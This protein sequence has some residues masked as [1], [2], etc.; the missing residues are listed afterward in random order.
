V[1]DVPNFPGQPDQP[2]TVVP[3]ERCIAGRDLT[4]SRLCPDGS[5][6][7][8]VE[9][10]ARGAAIVVVPAG[11]GPERTVTALVE[12][13]PGRGSGGG[14]FDWLPDGSGIVYVGNDGELWLQQLAATPARRLT[15]FGAGFTLTSPAVAADG[16][17]V[18]V[19]VDLA[20][21]HVVPITGGV[22]SRADDG[23][24]AFVIDPAW[25]PD[26]R[27]LAWQAWNPPDMPWDESAIVVASLE[28]GTHE[29]IL[30]TDA[31]CQQPRWGPDDR[32]WCVTDSS[33]WLNVARVERDAAGRLIAEPHVGEPFEHAG[34][35][36]GPG[37][38]SYAI[39]PDGTSVAFTRNEAGFGRLCRYDVNSGVVTEIARGVHVALHWADDVLVAIRSGARTPTEVVSYRTSGDGSRTRLAVGPLAGWDTAP[40]VEPEVVSCTAR[41]GATVFGR[42]YRAPNPTEGL[43]CWVHGGPTDQWQ[44]GF[45]PRFVHWISRG[46]SILVPDHRGSTGHGRVYQQAL[47]GRWGELDIDDVGDLLA[48]VQA[49][50]GWSP[51]ETLLMGSSAGGFTCLGV[52]ATEPSPAAAVVALYPVTDLAGLADRSHRFER[53]YTTTLVGDGVADRERY[54]VRSPM[55]RTADLARC[56]VLVMHGTDDPVVPID[57]SRALAAAVSAAGGTIRLHEFPG[58]GHGF[59][60]P[61]H[62]LAEYRLI[63]EFVDEHVASRGPGREGAR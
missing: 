49:T 54:R 12:P 25:S 51:G 9:R 43:I 39:S 24:D 6:V 2:L 20:E 62:Q 16:T 18:A 15:G 38:R 13:R 14:C 26:G 60:R 46:W 29:R 3:P 55:H 10:D 34:P 33:G 19:V 8:F 22:S 27:R 58:E 59:R 44:V 52:V 28:A 4:E 35:T 53:H 32:L 48:L 31:Q 50:E 5:I 47:R 45:L 1:P 30:M 7:A 17:S 63:A 37:Q 36:W 11:G 41:D 61:E 40:L 42:L 57:Q 56:P 23:S 21:V